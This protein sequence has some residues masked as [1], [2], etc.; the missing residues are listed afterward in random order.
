MTCKF[1]IIIIL[2]LK[3]LKTSGPM[4]AWRK[5]KGMSKSDV[6]N[7]SFKY[8]YLCTGVTVHQMLQDFNKISHRWISFLKYIY[9]S[10]LNVRKLAHKTKFIRA[11]IMFM[12]KSMARLPVC[13]HVLTQYFTWC[14]KR[15]GHKKNWYLLKTKKTIHVYRYHVH[16]INLWFPVG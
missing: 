5:I 12:W 11:F 13:E 4:T 1:L 15:I 3:L 7:L 2:L 8:M 10:K 6:L 9:P 14:W 16:T